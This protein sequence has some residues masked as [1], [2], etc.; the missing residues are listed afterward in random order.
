MKT[1]LSIPSKITEVQPKPTKAQIIEA[2]VDRARTK[3]DEAQQIILSKRKV[4]EDAITAEAKS[5]FDKMVFEFDSVS[6]YETNHNPHV[7][8]CT[9]QRLGYFT[10][11]KLAPLLAK[12]AKL[13]T[14]HFDEVKTKKRI[15]EGMKTRNP[16]L[17]NEDAAKALDALLK[18]I[19][20]P[21]APA[22]ENVTVDV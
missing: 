5:A 21:P 18:T 10:N 12:L 6:I 1:T 17:G 8:F 7:D 22:L 16:L 2:L 19:M 9:K 14:S 11:A 3:H 20:Q 15:V 4:L 13:Q